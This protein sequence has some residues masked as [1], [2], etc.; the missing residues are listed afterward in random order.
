MCVW[1]CRGGMEVVRVGH[2]TAERKGQRERGGESKSKYRLE[3]KSR[4]KKRKKFDLQGRANCCRLIVNEVSVMNNP[5]ICV[6]CECIY[7]MKF[8]F[9]LFVSGATHMRK[10]SSKWVQHFFS[11]SLP[12]HS[13]GGRWLL[14]F[15]LFDWCGTLTRAAKSIQNDRHI[16]SQRLCFHNTSNPGNGEHWGWEAPATRKHR[17]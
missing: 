7:L 8:F 9:C 1:V 12:L 11:A 3:K 2:Q 4:R 17:Q 5:L 16:F 15:A 10:T 13:G 14:P 6:Y